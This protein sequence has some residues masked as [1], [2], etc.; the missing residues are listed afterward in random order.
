MLKISKQS[1]EN[2]LEKI[3]AGKID[4]ITLSTS[5]LVDDIILEMH[6]QGV[7]ECIK[8]G[9]SDKRADNTTVP[10]DLT[11]ILAI[12]AKMKVH[13]SLTDIPFAL[14]DHRT[15]C[16]L[17]YSMWD[18]QKKVGAGLMSEGI[19]RNL[20][21]RYSAG[22][23]IFGYNRILQTQIMPHMNISPDI[24]ILDCTK[25]EVNYKNTNY[26]KSGISKDLDGKPMRGYKLATLRGI[27]KDSGIIED[28]RFGSA[29]IHDLELSR[30]MI[31]KSPVLKQG[32][33][34]INDR[35]FLSRDIINQLKTVRKVNT[36]VPLRKNMDAYHMAVSIAQKGDNWQAHP[37]KKRV[38][39]K[40]SFVSALGSF[41]RSDNPQNDVDINACVVWDTKTN[42]YFVFV[43]T[44][45]TKSATQII[46]T[47]ELR[48][49]IEE[50]YRQLKDFWK[51]EDFKSTKIHVISFHII[52]VLLG[53]LFFQLFTMTSAGEFLA[54]K[55]FPVLMKNYI[56]RSCN[57][58]IIYSEEIF[59]VL[60]MLEVVEI[61]SNC[62][63]GTKEKIAEILKWL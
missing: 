32:D 42:E 37:R 1:N 16:E 29:N 53:Y 3:A 13:S 27:V 43:T 7:T 58:M 35:G 19:I 34:L 45:T 11:L 59:W 24:H 38:N 46:K 63:P 36:Y 56:H 15:I 51:L 25:L 8:K 28:I 55:S 52:C 62:D 22:E 60:T 54:G 39:Q 18:K 21:G 5:S 61:Y 57:Y 9:L 30:D 12:A 4:A 33:T 20:I 49:E 44:D 23:L 26:E 14:T 41:W 6:K 31:F 2:I 17:G 48:P 10:F 47:Y 50:D 40:I